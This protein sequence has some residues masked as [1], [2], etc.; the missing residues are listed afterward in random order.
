MR[1]GASPSLSVFVDGA[2]DV[3]AAYQRGVAGIPQ[4]E[5]TRE[6]EFLSSRQAPRLL[7]AI[8]ARFEGVARLIQRSPTTLDDTSR[9]T[10]AH[11]I[12]QQYLASVAQARAI[13]GTIPTVHRWQ[14]TVFDLSIAQADET[15]IVEA[16][17]RDHV[18]LQRAATKA[19]SRLAPD[20]A[21]SFVTSSAVFFDFVHLSETGQQALAAAMVDEIALKLTNAPAARGAQ[22]EN[23]PTALAGTQ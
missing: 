14:P 15:A 18:L 19:V 21:V 5:A 8:A 12:A 1:C 22:C 3:F 4:N 23:V 2:N 10:L 11:S 6:L 9:Q 17:E 16:S 20:I 7:A 13:A